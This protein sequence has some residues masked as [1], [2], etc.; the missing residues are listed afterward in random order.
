MNKKISTSLV[1]SFL[2]ATLNINAEELSQITVS[3]ATKSEQSIQDVTSNIEVITKE[4]IDER[5]YSNIIEALNSVSGTSFVSNGGLGASTSF[6]IRGMA[7]ERIL[8]L[9]DGVK[10]RDPSNTSGSSLQHIFIDDIERIEI[11]KG[12]QSGIWGT[13]AAA[14]VINIITKKAENGFNS[15][16]NVEFG[17]YKT[18]KINT[19]VSYKE[20]KYDFK[21]TAN[22]I[23]SDGFST[24]VPYGDDVNSYEND[25]YKNLTLKLD[26]NIKV[27]DS[28]KIGFNL[29]SIDFLSEYDSF[30]TPNDDTLKSDG[31]SILASTYYEYKINNHNLKIQYEN[32]DFK[33]EEIGSTSGVLKFNGQSEGIEIS[34]SFKYS[35]ND[36]LIVGLGLSE[37][38]IDYVK[39]DTTKNNTNSKSSYLYFTNSNKFDK[40]IFTQ[41]LRYDR[42]SKF[43]NK[44][45]GKVGIKYS[46]DKNFNIFSNV[47]TAYNVPNIL[48]QLNPWGATFF[49]V[50]PEETKSFDIG[51]KYYDLK[52]TYFKSEVKNLI[53]WI[54]PTPLN[55]AN[56]DGYYK[57]SD[58]KSKF[59]GFEI[60]Y[61][62]MVTDYT[63]LGLAYTRLVA[64]NGDNEYLKKRPIQTFK[65][66]MDY[67]RLKNF[68]FNLNSEYVGT[69]YNLDNKSGRQTGKYTLWNG[70]INYNVSNDLKLYTKVDNIFNKYYQTTDSFATPGRSAYIGLNYKF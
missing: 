24:N 5:N 49:D 55:W 30:S 11:I 4:E 26:T 28:S 42:F 41:S 12:A 6:F 56:N 9:I 18:K 52:T 53:E 8:V 65:T 37:D 7:T 66:S 63:M 43:E 57:N 14:G 17:S 51:F 13:D 39:V 47:G 36:F 48:K 59:E 19:S 2:L 3:S 44:L 35:E 69:R 1:A 64:K 15:R 40:T 21:I 22:K 46:M 34:D 68:H 45:T 33:R 67:Y 25:G 62:K 61:S 10:Y 54:D 60:D 29:T 20:K 31:K 32:S 38:N 58:S 70:V 50:K 16:T 23:V 27:N